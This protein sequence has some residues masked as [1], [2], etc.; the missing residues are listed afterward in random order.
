MSRQGLAAAVLAVVACAI[1]GLMPAC[2]LAA[3]SVLFHRPTIDPSATDRVIV[4]WRDSGVAAVQIPSVVDRA[5]RLSTNTGVAVTAVRNL[6]GQVDV[7]RLDHALAHSAMLN[8]LGRL[9]TD[10]GV[11]YA[12]PDAQRFITQQFPSVAPNDPHFVAGSDAN[13]SWDGQWYLQPSSSSTPAAI[14]ATSAWL[15]TTGSSSVVVAVIDTGVIIDHPDLLPTSSGGKLLPGYDFVSCDQGNSTTEPSECS[16]SGSAATYYIANDNG[17]GWNQDASDPGDWISSADIAMPLFQ[18]DG[19]TTVEPSSWHG[20]KVAGVIGAITNNGVGIAGIAPDTLILPVRAIGV[21][22]GRVSDIA[23]AITWAAGL[24]VTGVPSLSSVAGIDQANIINLSLGA[25]TACSAT[26][27]DAIS[28]AIGAGILVVAAAGNE[29]GPV[30]APASCTGVLSVAGLRHT[31]TKVGY[32]SLSSAA[33][34]VSI[35]APAGNCVNVGTDVPCVYSIETTSD[36]GTT[37]PASTPGF[38]TY[39]VLDPSYLNGGGNPDNQANVGTSFAAPMAS[40]VAALMLATSPTLTPSELI[41]RMQSSALGFPGSSSTT[42]TTCVLAST[43]TDSNGNYTDTSQAI[44]CV[45]TTATCG[46]G[47]LN[48]AAA[49]TAAS[50]I[51]VQITPSSTTGSPGQHIRLDGSGSTPSTGDTI[52]SYQW[53]TIPATSNQLINANQAIATLVIPSFR[54]IQVELTITDSGGHTASGTATIQ[55]AFGAAS[56]V[57]SFGPELLALAVLTGAALRRRRRAM[58]AAGSLLN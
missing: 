4:K 15:T 23:A 24:A 49:V 51:Y 8:V 20:T 41:A 16:A 22:T 46:A 14:S 18:T 19:C 26:E 48:A 44:E 11:V 25:P 9:R 31:G 38:Y 2:S 35:A 30:D 40:G 3:D 32:S 39:A 42:S 43:A 21:C 17:L 5:A 1:G 36:A 28:A 53:V 27:Q 47:M 45:C 56:G 58:A 13:G 7:M 33:A 37:T 12:E 57:G 29:G 10:P 55:S 50:G 6:Y 52:V 54:S 34:A